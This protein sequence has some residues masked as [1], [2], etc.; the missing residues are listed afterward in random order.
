MIH[1]RFPRDDA[2]QGIARAAECQQQRPL[3]GQDI[4]GAC[5]VAFRNLKLGGGFL[6]Q[7]ILP[8]GFRPDQDLA[9]PIARAGGQDNRN[10]H[11]LVR[12][13][14]GR[15]GFGGGYILPRKFS[16]RCAAPEALR[17]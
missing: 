12:I 7:R 6:Q 11:R 5:G 17:P 9:K 16:A 4:G 3:G 2:R 15:S 10:R 13:G 8:C 14:G 1:D